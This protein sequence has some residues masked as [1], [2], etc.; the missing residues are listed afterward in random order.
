M[1]LTARVA[2]PRYPLGQALHA[3]WTKFRTV[4]GPSAASKAGSTWTGH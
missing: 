3:E 1:S 2:P 4:A